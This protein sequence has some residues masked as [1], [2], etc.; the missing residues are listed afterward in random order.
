MK[1]TLVIVAVALAV[2]QLASAVL[3]FE[4]L[5]ANTFTVSHQVKAFGGRGQAMEL[6]YEKA[7]S[8]CIA[9]GYSY[10]EVMEQE[11][12]AGGGWEAPNAT[13]TVKLYHERGDDRIACEMKSSREYI[14]QAKKKLDK[15][16]YE[17]PV[18]PHPSAAP[19]PDPETTENFCTVEQI[20]AMVKAGLTE[21]QIKAACAVSD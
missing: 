20:A 5:D 7:A 13:V 21:D 9:A 18:Q 2:P 4:Q 12:H 14:A 19:Q 11:S 6:V 10:M 8:L 3:T 15:R 1:K 16:G 17:G